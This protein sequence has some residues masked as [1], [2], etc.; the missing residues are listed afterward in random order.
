MDAPRQERIHVGEIWASGARNT[1]FLLRK[2]MNI[3]LHPTC[4]GFKNGGAVTNQ[5]RD[6]CVW[7]ER[8]TPKKKSELSP[9]V[10]WRE[11][12][13]CRRVQARTGQECA[14]KSFIR[15]SVESGNRS[16]HDENLHR[17]YNE[18]I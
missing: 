8:R 6:Q 5:R 10:A 14:E 2:S 3:I 9:I 16:E 4:N 17:R 18:Q 11:R 13:T 15:I 12:A 7:V 1:V